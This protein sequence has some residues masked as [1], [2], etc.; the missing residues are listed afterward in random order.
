MELPANAKQI[1]LVI[2]AMLVVIAL[3]FLLPY[4]GQKPSLI[5]YAKQYMYAICPLMIPAR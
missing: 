1:L 5:P 3:S 4:L 2:A